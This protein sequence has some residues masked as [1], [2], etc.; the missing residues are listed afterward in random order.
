[1]AAVEVPVEAKVQWISGSCC[2]SG[3]T[4]ISG[5]TIFCFCFLCFSCL[6]PLQIP[7]CTPSGLAFASDIMKLRFHLKPDEVPVVVEEAPS[8]DEEKGPEAKSSP[9]KENEE[10]DVV[11]KEF[12]H[13]VLAVEGMAQVW[14]TRD[15]LIAYLL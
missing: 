9:T 6:F 11:T 3:S 8:N 7:P 15:L 14:T 5:Y 1:M 12:Q 2:T 4:Y 13:G 10:T